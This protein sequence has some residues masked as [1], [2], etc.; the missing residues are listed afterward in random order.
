MYRQSVPCERNSSYNFIPIFLKLCT[1]LLHGLKICMWFGYNPCINFCYFFHF[2]NFVIFW[3][4]ILW[5]GCDSGF[6]ASATPHT[7]LYRSFWNFVYVFAMVWRCAYDLDIILELNFVTFCRSC[8]SMGD[9]G[10]QV[11]VRLFVLPFVH[12]S[13]NIYHGCPVSAT[14]LTVFY[15]SFWNFADVFFMVWGCACG[16]D[17]IIRLFFITFYTLFRPQCIDS[18]YL[19]SATLI[20]FYTNLYETCTCV[21]H[22]QEMCTWFGYNPWINFCHFFHF[23]NFVIFWPQILW[24]CLDSGYLVSATPYTTSCLSLCNFA[25][26]F[27]HGLKMCMWFGFNPAVNCRTCFS[28]GDIGVQ[29]SIRLFVRLSVHPSVRLSV[30]IYHGRLMS[31][32]P[33]TVF[34]QSFWNFADVFF[35]LWRCARGLDIIVRLFFITFSTLW[36]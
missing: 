23:V 29:V 12:L 19:V 34:Y 11:S 13:V 31:V 1:W 26:L 28:M 24:K 7:I 8:F 4:Q 2:A 15:R 16:L 36:T 22:G 17:I 14:T 25:H 30:N 20:Q 27:F 6:L 18:G 33:L 3:P 10:V 9:L 21:C 5:K 32:T 35:L